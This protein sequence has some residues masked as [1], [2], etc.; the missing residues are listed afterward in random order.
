MIRTVVFAFVVALAATAAP[1]SAQTAPPSASAPAAEAS[2]SG[3]GRQAMA[4]CRDDIKSLCAGVEN[5][6]GRK[7]ACLK[8]NQAKLSTGCQSAI[9]SVLDKRGMGKAPVGAGAM[10]A[11]A[12]VKLK[13][14]CQTDIA[15]QCAGVIAG[16]GAVRNCL[17]EKSPSLSQPCQAALAEA[18][19]KGAL[20]SQAKLTCASDAAT[21]CPQL[22]GK[23]EMTCLQIKAASAS[24]ACQQMLA[25]IPAPKPESASKP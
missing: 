13:Q 20:R 19:A 5:G 14:V 11:N 21:L 7:I 16:K 6:G 15:A 1:V 4:A 10:T 2:A 9:Q 8:E 24:S 17:N 22:Q 12:G 23:A 18:K 25:K 3:G